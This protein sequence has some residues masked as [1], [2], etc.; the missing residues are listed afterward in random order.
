MPERDD[1]RQRQLRLVER[2]PDDRRA[3][4]AQISRRVVLDPAGPGEDLL[5]LLL[6]DRDDPAARVEQMQRDDA[7]P[8]SIAAM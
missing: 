1:V 4:C 6:A 5:V 2:V 7:V 3:R 8:W